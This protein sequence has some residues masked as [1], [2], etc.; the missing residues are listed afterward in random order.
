MVRDSDKDFVTLTIQR[1]DEENS[2]YQSRDPRCGNQTVSHEM[3]VGD[4]GYI[5]ISEFSK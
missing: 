2:E 3:L 5:R 1:E 4:T